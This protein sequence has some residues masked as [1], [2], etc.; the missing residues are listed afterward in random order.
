MVDEVVMGN[1]PR[2]AKPIPR[3]FDAGIDVSIGCLL[4]EVE[5]LVIDDFLW[6]E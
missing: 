6:D 4:I 5:V 1:L 2:F 3:A